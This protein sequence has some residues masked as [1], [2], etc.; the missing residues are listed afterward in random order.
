[1]RCEDRQVTDG[2][3]TSGSGFTLIELLVV[4]AIIALLMAILFPALKAACSQARAVACQANLRQWGMVYATFAAEND[5][6]FPNENDL[7][8][9]KHLWSGWMWGWDDTPRSPTSGPKRVSTSPTSSPTEPWRTSTRGLMC[10]PMAAKTAPPAENTNSEW[11]GTFYAWSIFPVHGSYGM[12]TWLNYGTNPYSLTGKPSYVT[13]EERK[14]IIEFR[15]ASAVPLLL[16]SI[17]PGTCIV[18][19]KTVPPFYDAIPTTPWGV[20]NSCINRHHGWVNGVFV[21]WSAR[22]VGLKE[23]WTLKWYD[24]YDTHGP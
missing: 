10:C 18:D 6:R 14:R 4:I 7:R 11:G 20:I 13:E 21:D 15:P 3:W 12:N 17:C 8:D 23:L 9:N 22:T 16:D 24:K 19:E 1:M 2:H 5:G